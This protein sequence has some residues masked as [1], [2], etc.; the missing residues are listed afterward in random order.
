M[1]LKR[2]PALMSELKKARRR[3]LSSLS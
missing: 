3:R 2:G 1:P